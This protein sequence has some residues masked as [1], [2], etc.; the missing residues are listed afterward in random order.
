MLI[1]VLVFFA[2]LSGIEGLGGM[3]PGGAKIL[4]EEEIK[5]DNVLQGIED[6]LVQIADIYN[7]RSN[8]L[9]AYR[10]TQT[11]QITKRVVA[12]FEYGITVQFTP[13]ECKKNTDKYLKDDLKNCQ[14]SAENGR[15]QTCTFTAWYRPWLILG[16]PTP[17]KID[18][19]KC[20]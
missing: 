13:T 9:Y 6:I 12:G 11:V 18:M 14:L 8:A 19:K 17:L 1:T 7:K 16:A 5:A 3:M 20:N 4:T 2:A 10:I 15:P